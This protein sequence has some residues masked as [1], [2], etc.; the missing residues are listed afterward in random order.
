MPPPVQSQTPF[1]SEEECCGA[2]QCSANA[3]KICMENLLH[4]TGVQNYM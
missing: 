1:L 2:I 3:E 4:I